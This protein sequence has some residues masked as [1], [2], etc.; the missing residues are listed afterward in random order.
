M[1]SQFSKSTKKSEEYKLSLEQLGQVDEG[2]T[3]IFI[4]MKDASKK[5]EY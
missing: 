2:Y 5:V 1:N 4:N 3:V